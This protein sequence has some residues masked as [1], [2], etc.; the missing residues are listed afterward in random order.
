MIAVRAMPGRTSGKIMHGAAREI[1]KET[2]DSYH[3]RDA[4]VIRRSSQ[5]LPC[6]LI[7]Y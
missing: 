3:A 1:G 6:F 5:V 7:Y 4:Y 2:Y